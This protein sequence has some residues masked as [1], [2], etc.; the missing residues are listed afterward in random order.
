[1]VVAGEHVPVCAFDQQAATQSLD[2]GHAVVGELAQ[3]AFQAARAGGTPLIIKNPGCSQTTPTR[4][5]LLCSS[6]YDA[7]GKHHGRLIM[8]PGGQAAMKSG[9]D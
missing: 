7:D 4:Y 2:L 3:R 1:M 6:H 9:M 5:D 8:G